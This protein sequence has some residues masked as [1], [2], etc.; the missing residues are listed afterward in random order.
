[1]ENR[2]TYAHD[3]GYPDKAE[4]YVKRGKQ[5]IGQ[6]RLVSMEVGQLTA[7]R[8]KLFNLRFMKSSK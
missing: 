3:A 7:L 8:V 6:L 4:G 5:F 2:V 1:M